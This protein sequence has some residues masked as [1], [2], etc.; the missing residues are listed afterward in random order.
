MELIKRITDPFR[1][2]L[3]F[4]VALCVFALLLYIMATLPGHMGNMCRIGGNMSWQNTLF[5]VLFS[6][7]VAIHV[8]VL[9]ELLGAPKSPTTKLP[10]WLAGLPVLGTL[11]GIFTVFCTICALPIV[12]LFG[13]SLSLGFFT[14]YSIYIQLGSILLLCFSLYF[15]ERYLASA[16]RF[17][18]L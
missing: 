6:A 1:F 9:P 17:C 2:L 13:A 5:A 7:L 15:V 10:A 16:C 12:V 3:M 11:M 18:T 14:T 8:V 4:F